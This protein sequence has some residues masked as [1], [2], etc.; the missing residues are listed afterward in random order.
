MPRS[1]R[2]SADGL[3]GGPQRSPALI[4]MM[5]AKN[6]MA[7]DLASRTAIPDRD[8]RTSGMNPVESRMR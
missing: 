1:H 8:H 5:T 7:L 2:L 4:R 6:N 3:L